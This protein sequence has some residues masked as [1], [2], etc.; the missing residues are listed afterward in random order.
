[1]KNRNLSASKFTQADQKGLISMTDILKTIS[2]EKALVLF[3]TIALA[4]GETEIQIRK[5]GLT[6]KQYYSRISKMIKTDLIRRNNGRYFLTLLGKIVYEV[7][8]TIGKG[9]NYYWK[10]KALDSI[11]TSSSAGLPK[12]ELFKPIDILID[13]YQIKDIFMKTPLPTEDQ[14]SR[15]PTSQITT[16]AKEKMRLERLVSYR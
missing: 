2:D 10:L 12:E 7:H 16:G 8:L 9:L 4:N 15:D 14:Q 5:M 6:T 1:L 3:N 11:Q 13:N